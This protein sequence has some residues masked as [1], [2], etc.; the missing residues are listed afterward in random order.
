MSPHKN[1]LLKKPISE[2]PGPLNNYLNKKSKS[3]APKTDGYLH[4][5]IAHKTRV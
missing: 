5:E 3:E 4:L 1:Y 2:T